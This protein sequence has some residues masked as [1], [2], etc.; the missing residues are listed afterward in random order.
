MRDRLSRERIAELRDGVQ[1]IAEDAE[2]A[3][4][5][6]AQNGDAGNAAASAEHG[7]V[8][9]DLLHVLDAYEASLPP[10]SECG[11]G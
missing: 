11:D 8:F 5:W 10:V 4:K 1:R 6:Y 3:R 2:W 9:D 7:A